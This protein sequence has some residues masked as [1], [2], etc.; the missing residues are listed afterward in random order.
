M[1]TMKTFIV[2]RIHRGNWAV[3]NNDNETIGAGYLNW[4]VAEEAARHAALNVGGE[5]VRLSAKTGKVVS[6]VVPKVGTPSALKNARNKASQTATPD[7]VAVPAYDVAL[8]ESETPTEESLNTLPTAALIAAYN[9][10][11]GNITGK[12]KGSRAKLVAKILA[13]NAS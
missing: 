7:I 8:D 9:A 3:T 6:H 11:G 13:A 10:V 4:T 12:Y 1:K 2:S 5:V